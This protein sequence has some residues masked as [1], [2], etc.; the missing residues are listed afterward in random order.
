M[1]GNNHSRYCTSGTGR[2]DNPSP[3]F[4]SL[5]SL[6][7]PLQQQTV[8]AQSASPT[9]A[10]ASN[11]LLTPAETPLSRMEK[12]LE[13]WC[14]SG[15]D[16]EKE[17]RKF[18]AQQILHAFI[19]DAP[20]LEIQHK[21]ISSLPDVIGELKSLK[22]L[23]V[24]HTNIATL[25]EPIGDLINLE[26]L[27][28]NNNS[29]LTALPERTGNLENLKELYVGYTGLTALPASNKHDQRRSCQRKLSQHWRSSQNM[30]Q[31]SVFLG[32]MARAVLEKPEHARSSWQARGTFLLTCHI[33]HEVWAIE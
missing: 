23:S 26:I 13:A 8:S 22:Q 7:C 16:E 19:S 1:M 24:S 3:P 17:D 28:V 21:N 11:T 18:V 9:Q 20:K 31:V 10:L 30:T 12:V 4:D 14:Q 29:H 32:A 5:E 25:P 2:V 6:P 15:P 33:N 27:C